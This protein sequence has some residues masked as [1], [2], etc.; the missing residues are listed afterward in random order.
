[1]YLQDVFT[2]T[3][4]LAGIPGASVPIGQMGG[5]PVG[6]QFLAPWWREESMLAAAGALEAA[7]AGDRR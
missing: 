2:V 4:N 7:L 1:M 6:G 5:L 3:A